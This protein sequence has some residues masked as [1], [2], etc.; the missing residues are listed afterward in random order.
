MTS[1]LVIFS[2]LDGPLRDPSASALAAAARVLE[3]IAPANVSV[4]LTSR[5]T[6]A[7]LEHIQQELGITDPFICESGAALFIPLACF[8]GAV[9]GSRPVAGYNVVEFG[10]AYSDV[11]STLYRTADDLGIAIE[12]FSDMSVEDVARDCGLT[13]LRARLAKLREYDEPFRILD[14]RPRARIRLFKALRA[15]RLQCTSV[16]RYHHAGARL[17]EYAAVN[18]LRMLYEPAS[19][20]LLTVGLVDSAAG[21]DR[22]DRPDYL[23]RLGSDDGADASLDI[24]DWALAIEDVVS[25]VRRTG[26]PSVSG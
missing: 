14:P 7:E 10:R 23:V 8:G 2:A 22:L 11:V 9:P 13:L 18:L 1:R 4:I 21:H 26:V 6:R 5:M 15:A 16:G 24:V 19:S 17:D 3:A 25:E 20:R 12:G